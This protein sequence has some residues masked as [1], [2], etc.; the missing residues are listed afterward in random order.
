MEVA[1]VDA[2]GLDLSPG[3]TAPV[4]RNFAHQDR[5]LAWC[6]RKNEYALLMEQGTGK[7]RIV[8]IDGATRF[9]RAEI[10]RV[11]VLAPNGVHTNWIRRELPAH[12]P[13]NVMQPLA[14]VW[15]SAPRAEEKN[16]LV[17]VL[18]SP[19]EPSRLRMLA[20]NWEALNTERGYAE[21]LRFV[22]GGRCMIVGDESHFI[23]SPS[24][25]RTRAA[26]RLRT[27]AAVRVILS[28]T[29]IVNSPWDAYSQFGFLNPTILRSAS[30][31]AFKAEYAQLLPPGH[32]LLRHISMRTGGAHMPQIV[33]R[34]EDGKP[35]WR[36]LAQLHALIEPH[37]F[38]VLKR[39]CLDLPEKIYTQRFYR[40]TP[41]VAAVYA[42]LLSELRFRL[43]SGEDHAVDRIAS[44]TKLSQITSGYFI[45]PGTDPSS[46]IQTLVS[47]GEN[48]KLRAAMEEVE[49]AVAEGEQ[50]IVWARFHVELE[51]LRRALADVP[52]VVYHGEVARQDRSDAIDKFQSGAAR[53]FLGQQAAGGTGITLTAA[54]TVIYFSN[55]WSLADRLQSEDRAHRIGQRRAVRYVDLIGLET[56]DERL[57]SAL[58][59]KEDVARIILGDPRAAARFLA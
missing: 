37:S 17:A 10:D 36:N 14:A 38:R 28:G 13:H 29:A 27:W 9:L 20:M 46:Q 53:V 44:L 25:S 23:K 51:M 16:A 48:P 8:L 33:A 50:V 52:H 41:R 11:L 42:R 49:T 2:V 12:W 58:Q 59:R 43:S 47:P 30:Y 56:I 1:A 18:S 55:T 22:K 26:L 7:T 5:A 45:E 57:V 3:T 19:L 35:I 32:G 54:S 40:M 6:S 31:A 39:D 21:A 34:G 4:A 24:A 15:Y